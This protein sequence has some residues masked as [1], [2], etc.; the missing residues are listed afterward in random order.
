M[1]S[2][3]MF[4]AELMSR[5]CSA[6][7]HSAHADKG[8]RVA[9]VRCSLDTAAMCRARSFVSPNQGAIGSADG[10]GARAAGLAGDVDVTDLLPDNAPA[11][12]GV[13]GRSS[14]GR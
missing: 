11:L 12:Y 9:A 7:K 5:S 13:S 6:Q 8:F 2:A 14:V 10:I 4:L 1:P 3:S